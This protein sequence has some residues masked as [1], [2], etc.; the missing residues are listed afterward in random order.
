MRRKLVKQKLSLR[1]WLIK[2][3]LPKGSHVHRDPVSK[4]KVESVEV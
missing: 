3:L 1:S 4:E 2:K